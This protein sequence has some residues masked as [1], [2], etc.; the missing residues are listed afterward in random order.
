MLKIKH[1]SV[2]LIFFLSFF[3]N[4][5]SPEIEE[6]LTPSEKEWLKKH[7]TMRL[8][9]DSSS[10]FRG[11]MDEKGNYV[12]MGADYVRMLEKKTG[13]SFK[14]ELSPTWSRII[15]K[16]KSREIDVIPIIAST[17]EREAFLNFSDSIVEMPNVIITRKNNSDIKSIGDLDGKTVSINK[18]YVVHEW[19]AKNYPLIILRP[20]TD[21]EQG[22]KA[23]AIGEVDAYIG[24]LATAVH[25]I[26]HLYLPDM[27]IAAEIPFL[28]KW[29][30]A[31]R[32]DWPEFIPILNKAI[33]RITP[34]ENA[35]IL[36]KWTTI[37]KGMEIKEFLM[38]LI[39]AVIAVALLTLMFSNLRLRK[40]VSKRKKAEE[41]LHIEMA[42][43]EQI[44][45][46]RLLS[47]EVLKIL[48]E[49]T[50]FSLSLARVISLIKKH[51]GSDAIGIRLNSGEDFPYFVQDGF[52]RDFLLK[53]NTLAAHGQD[54][55]ICRSSD[56]TVKLECTC[57][58]V[59]SGRTDPSN[60]LFTAGGSFWTNDS[61]LLLDL[62]PDADP[63]INP[64][65]QCIHDGYSSVAL[66][67][68]RATHKIV[69]LLHLN[70]RDKCRF[71]LEAIQSLELLSTHIGEALIRN[72]D[73]KEH[74]LDE[75]RL[76]SLHRISQFKA[77]SIQELLDFALEE[78][79]SLTGSKIGY[80]YHYSEEKKEF[81]LNTWSKDV[82]KECTV[83][84]PQTCYELD[85]TGV[86]GE[87]VRQR[88]PILINDFPA[89]HPLKK[90]YPEGHA[91]LYKFLTIPVFVD[92]KIVAVAA[93]ANKETD[94]DQSDVR[95]LNLL[96]D[97]VWKYVERKESE[98]D[99]ELLIK[100]LKKALAEV[101][102]LGALLPICASCKK[103]R[104]DKG[105]W[106][107]LESY[108]TEHTDT[109]F[110]HGICPDCA[111]AL[112][113]DLV[114]EIEKIEQANKNT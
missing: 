36:N 82:M 100:D 113:P 46:Y 33:S 65:N 53:E 114:A 70:A 5:Q 81:I 51:T 34:E 20:K 93:V 11:V 96:M 26:N 90:G 8:G 25:A 107:N 6:I 42:R 52:S 98:A 95:Q 92:D 86:W 55:G 15:E 32:E 13:V 30:I 85:K 104:D 58:L 28:V 72:M 35:I 21:T 102:V 87:A 49:P 10:Y 101:K 9:V 38:Y 69:G 68:I 27:K 80:I 99:K 110:S 105:Y 4:A 45:H 3:L 76:E 1:L 41:T 22:L 37:H 57:G 54:G 79:I 40:E 94:Y 64:R 84:N 75:A 44:E 111:K 71:T 50:D 14:P 60:P 39:P 56:G 12:G 103:I 17:P 89:Q 112:Y 62:P 16:A 74:R 18:D 108:L 78:T 23:V 61:H 47:I 67:P 97:T 59:I 66:V 83:T 43:R 109:Q 19:V 48:N 106:A 29:G 31:V 77:K 7:P 88:K 91:K 24:D 63:R 2:L 73:E